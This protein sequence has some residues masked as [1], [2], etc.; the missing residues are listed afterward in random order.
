[1][2][3]ERAHGPSPWRDAPGDGGSANAAEAVTTY[4]CG[5][6][7]TLSPD[8]EELTLSADAGTVGTLA[9]CREAVGV[10]P[11]SEVELKADMSI[12]A[13]SDTVA[14]HI[15]VTEVIEDLVTYKVT[16]WEAAS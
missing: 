10:A 2:R 1:M 5:D 15:T 12:C 9:S 14:A 4:L 8:D 16:A 6:R 13:V 3:R 11:L 7:T